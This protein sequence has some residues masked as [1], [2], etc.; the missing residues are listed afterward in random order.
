MLVVSVLEV[1]LSTRRASQGELR[2]FF[3]EELVVYVLVLI[4]TTN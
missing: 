1:G 4:L 3:G 2:I